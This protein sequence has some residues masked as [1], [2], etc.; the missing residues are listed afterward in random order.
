MSLA[1]DSGSD[2][3][4]RDAFGQALLSL[5]SWFLELVPRFAARRNTG[6]SLWQAVGEQAAAFTLLLSDAVQRS[7]GAYLNPLG[8]GH[9]F[10]LK[11]KRIAPNSACIWMLRAWIYG[12]EMSRGGFD[13]KKSERSKISCFPTLLTGRP[14]CFLKEVGHSLPRLPSS[15]RQPG[16]W[17]SPVVVRHLGCR[18]EVGF[19]LRDI[20]SRACGGLHRIDC[21]HRQPRRPGTANW[22]RRLLPNRSGSGSARRSGYRP[23]RVGRH[24]A[25]WLGAEESHYRTAFGQ[26]PSAAQLRTS[27]WRTERHLGLARVS[28]HEHRFCQHL[29][30]SHSNHPAGRFRCCRH[31]HNHR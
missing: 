29:S 12:T 11:R 14:V 28:Q 19:G 13:W 31:S 26:N 3:I 5:V 15:M 21:I 27:T 22:K 23:D 30:D 4:K 2:I 16:M 6:M 1:K 10:S 25:H 8:V 24:D 7:S 9:S 17:S 18:G 20:D